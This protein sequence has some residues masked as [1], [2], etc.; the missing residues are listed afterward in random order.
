MHRIIWLTFAMIAFERGLIAWTDRYLLSRPVCA[1]YAAQLRKRVAVFCEWCGSDIEIEAVDC[2]LANEWLAELV[3]AGKN[4]QT[5]DGYRRALLAVW[6][7]AYLSGDNENP[8][9]RLRK[10]KKPRLIIEAYSHDEIKKLLA[11]ASKLITEHQDGNRAKDFWQAAIHVAYS[12]G[13]RRGDVLTLDWKHVAPSGR[14]TFL[15]N[16][17]Q[18]THTVKLSEDAIKYARKLTSKGKVLPWPYEKN[19]FGECFARLRESAGVKRGS[20]KWLRRSAGSYAESITPGAGARLLGHRD[21]RMFSKHY[22][23]SEIIGE[24]AAEPPPI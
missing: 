6:N 21:G 3:A 7:D 5:I 4:P 15:Q 1:Q 10:I 20:F 24:S 22:A 14:L 18:Y 12:C 23:D 17:T 11:A 2:D 16:K 19:W 13:A 9:L 8:P